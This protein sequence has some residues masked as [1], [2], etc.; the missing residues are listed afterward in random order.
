MHFKDRK[1][2]DILEKIDRIL[3]EKEEIAPGTIYIAADKGFY[4]H[5]VIDAKKYSKTD[6]IATFVFTKKGFDNKKE[7]KIERFKLTKVR[8]YKPAILPEWIPKEVL[9]YSKKLK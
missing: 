5:L 2:D 6:E 4:G 8:Y 1:M 9:D 3:E 7:N